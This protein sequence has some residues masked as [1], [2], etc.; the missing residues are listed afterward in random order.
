MF[1]MP[2][3]GSFG[4]VEH[5]Y[6][7]VST[8]GSTRWRPS[9]CSGCART[10]RA[11][12]RAPSPSRCWWG[13]CWRRRCWR[14]PPRAPGLEGRH[15]GAGATSARGR[16]HATV[17]VTMTLASVQ[18]GSAAAAALDTGG[19]IPGGAARRVGV[20]PRSSPWPRRP[21]KPLDVAQTRRFR[22]TT[23]RIAMGISRQECTARGCDAP[24]AATTRSPPPDLAAVHFT[25]D[26]PYAVSW[27]TLE[28]PSKL[29]DPMAYG[30]VGAVLT[31][32]RRRSAPGRLPARPTRG[33]PPAGG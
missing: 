33:A 15:P 31:G 8:V 19:R 28:R 17:V 18:G 2:S 14:S 22:T 30:E 29:G 6:F 3:R 25:N 21:S 10:A 1:E 11:A 24:P 4:G 13:R 23:Q 5:S 12:S 16:G 7:A 9:T 20:R 26:A 27:R 32:S